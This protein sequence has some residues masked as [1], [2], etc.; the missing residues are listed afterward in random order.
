MW[1]RG[2]CDHNRRLFSLAW[3]RSRAT[4][5]W[6]CSPSRRPRSRRRLPTP[7][8]QPQARP[9]ARAR[10]SPRRRGRKGSGQRPAAEPSGSA[11]L[12]GAS[13]IDWTH[14]YAAIEVAADQPGPVRGARER[15][16]AVRGGAARTPRATRSRRASAN[17]TTPSS[18]RSRGSR[19]SISCSGRTSAPSS[20]SSHSN[21]SS[22]SS[23]P[24]PHGTRRAD[25]RA[26]RARRR[27]V[28]S[29]SRA[30]CRRRA[31]T[32]LAGLRRAIEQR[33]P[34]ARLDLSSVLT[35]DDAGARTAR[36][37]AR[38]GAPPALCRSSIERLRD[39]RAPRPRRR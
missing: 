16:A 25:R 33:A 18:R 7:R 23:G 20:T 26:G 10:R 2:L 30:S 32:Q 5:R 28:T 38:A 13:L 35:F 24:R 17:D 37:L 15:R 22:S 4:Q 34:N 29:R 3:P 14:A 31:A 36:R 39:A 19:C 11:T 8:G 27:A 9:D 1:R 21:T 12:T 6:R